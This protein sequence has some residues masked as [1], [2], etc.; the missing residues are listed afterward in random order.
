MAA[1]DKPIFRE[2]RQIALDADRENLH[3]PAIL[4]EKTKKSA[5]TAKRLNVL[6]ASTDCNDNNG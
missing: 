5:K 1:S 2:K 4:P 3:T 6:A